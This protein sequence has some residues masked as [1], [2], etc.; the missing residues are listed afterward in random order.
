MKTVDSIPQMLN[1]IF[2]EFNEAAKVGVCYQSHTSANKD[3]GVQMYRITSVNGH[4]SIP[5]FRLAL[6]EMQETLLHRLMQAENELEPANRSIFLRQGL[7]KCKKLLSAITP[8]GAGYE[9]ANCAEPGISCHVFREP[10]CVDSDNSAI[11]GDSEQVI[12]ELSLLTKPYAESWHQVVHDIRDEF[13][14]A[15]GRVEAIHNQA[16]WKQNNKQ[17]RDEERKIRVKTN[18]PLLAAFFRMLFDLGFFD[19]DNKSR[20]CRVIVTLSILNTKRI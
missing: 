20:F 5:S 8:A 4:K 17:E 19:M 1:E 11:A 15:L 9:E 7:H 3:T 2:S 16:L 13:K 18:L 6:Y 14:Y 10:S 12:N